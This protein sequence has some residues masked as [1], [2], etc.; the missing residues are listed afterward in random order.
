MLYVRLNMRIAVAC[1]VLA[2]AV[3]IDARADNPEFDLSSGKTYLFPG[4]QS[5][6]G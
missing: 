5:A 6:G 4:L 3:S 2:W 1:C